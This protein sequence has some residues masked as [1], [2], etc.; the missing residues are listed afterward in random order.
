M[1][2]TYTF[3]RGMLRLVI[4]GDVAPRDIVDAIERAKHDSRFRRGMPMLVDA[5]QSLTPSASD[6]RLLAAGLRDSAA[7]LVGRVAVVIQG[8]A[9]FGMARMAQIL[10][11]GTLDMLVTYDEGEAR[12]WLTESRTV[13]LT[14]SHRDSTDGP[15]LCPNN[16]GII[17]ETQK[18]D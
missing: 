12:A 13:A 1:A 15:E 11:S 14:A 4:D 8:A 17:S 3:E 10:L 9:A 5:R 18:G 2:V 7:P 6:V 16:D